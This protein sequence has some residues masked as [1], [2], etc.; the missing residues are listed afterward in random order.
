MI[1]VLARIAAR[2]VAGFLIAKGLLD[3]GTGNMLATDPDVLT[4]V[5]LG[6]GVL[7]ELAYTVARKMGWEK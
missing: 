4:L 1:A 7:T 5:G 3:A 2:Y 6:I